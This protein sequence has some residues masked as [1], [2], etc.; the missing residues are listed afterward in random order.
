MTELGTTPS[1][2]EKSR[3]KKKLFDSKFITEI[4]SLSFLS[5]YVR[6]IA[7]ELAQTY[8]TL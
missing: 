4:N 6:R 8:L 5:L 3:S 1:N 7:L 2:K